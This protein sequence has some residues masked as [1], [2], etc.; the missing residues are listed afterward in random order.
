MGTRST[1]KIYENGKL[2]LALYKHWDG[3]LE[4]WGKELKEFLS[5]KKFVNGIRLGEEDK[6]FNGIGDFA[7]QLVCKFKEGSGGLYATTEDDKQA[8]N[9]VIESVYD[10]KGGY[11]V[12]LKCLEEPSFGETIMRSE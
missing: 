6:V 10:E 12:T 1:T 11:T 8:F 3:Y 4:G 7:L 2:I 5:S 9:Y